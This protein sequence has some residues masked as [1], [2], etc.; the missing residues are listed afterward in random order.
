MQK[1]CGKGTQKFVN[2][3]KVNIDWKDMILKAVQLGCLPLNYPSIA[4]QLIWLMITKPRLLGELVHYTTHRKWINTSNFITVVDVGGYIGSFSYAIHTLLPKA[5]IYSFEPIQNNYD[6]LM[7]NMENIPSFYAFNT[8]LGDQRGEVDFFMNEF[9]PS[10]SMLPMERLLKDNYPY[11]ANSTKVKV[12]IAKLD[13]F[14]VEINL[15]SP[16]ILKIDVQGYEEAVLRGATE[17]LK[18]TDVI[19]LEVSYQPLYLR[20]GTFNEIYKL[21]I[22]N[23][24]EF[25]GCF[26]PML[27]KLDGSILQSDAVFSK[28]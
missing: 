12:K 25:K 3:E 5:R 18:R 28:N 27:S 9:S 6:Q 7:E 22:E 15:V 26:A 4:I 13:D 20:Q 11:A 2:M 21:L 24:F 16:V 1:L 10:S 17:T 14:L 19:I 8:A 23:G